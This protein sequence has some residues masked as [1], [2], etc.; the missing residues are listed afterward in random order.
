LSDYDLVGSAV[1]G[2]GLFALDQVERFDLLYLPPPARGVDVGPA[3]TLAAASEALGPRHA[4]VARELTKV[5]EEV[6]R[7][8]LAEVAE[9]LGARELKGEVVIVIGPPDRSAHSEPHPDEIREAV[10]ALIEAGR[11][12][13]DA[14][15]QVADSL[16]I[17]KNAVYRAA[18]DT[19]G[20]EGTEE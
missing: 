6:V 4:A 14:V 9:T 12:R 19:D 5:Y 20:V 8:P 3:A 18:L 10:G 11:S 1:R 2:T 13:K 16:G 7:G 17:G 15:A